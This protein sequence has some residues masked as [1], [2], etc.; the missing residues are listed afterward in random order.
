MPVI[1][2]AGLGWYGYQANGPWNNRMF[3]AGHFRFLFY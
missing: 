2:S 1:I 3:A